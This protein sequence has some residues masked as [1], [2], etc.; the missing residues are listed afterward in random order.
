[1][2]SKVSKVV[3]VDLCTTR[4]AGLK[5][6][7][8]S[9][10]AEIAINGVSHKLPDVIAI[11]QGAID[12]RA[13]VETKKAEIQE[14]MATRADAEAQRRAADRALKPWV[15]NQF[16][17]TSQQAIDFGFPPNKTPVRTVESK[18]QAVELALATRE[19]R[20]TMGKKEKLK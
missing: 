4:L 19:A 12:S 20:G 5:A 16:G 11:Y 7:V 15:I 18:K 9:N 1:M 3:A 13:A 6:Y 10:K 14:A 17:A 2:A 8:K